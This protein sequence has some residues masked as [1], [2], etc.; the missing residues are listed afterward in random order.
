LARAPSHAKD[1]LALSDL[2]H[3]L[4]ETPKGTHAGRR[5][6]ALLLV[7]ISAALRRA[8]LVALDVHDVQFEAEGMLVSIRASRPTRTAR[9]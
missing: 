8:E 6:R 2:D 7:A 1:A 4:A 3:I 9:A 5:D